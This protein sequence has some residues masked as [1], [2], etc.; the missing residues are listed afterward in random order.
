MTN[1]E[2]QQE[3]TRLLA[4][5]AKRTVFDRQVA[6][7]RRVIGHG[8]NAKFVLAD[9]WSASDAD[10]IAA[11]PD[12]AAHIRRLQA[13]LDDRQA[14]IDEWL[15]KTKWMEKSKNIPRKYL[16]MHKADVLKNMLDDAQRDN[17]QRKQAYT[18][19]ENI[20]LEARSK[21]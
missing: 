17:D 20:L 15:D 10:F 4:L 8:P 16:G 2:L 18:N 19:I 6:D 5:D 12:M 13:A 21:T 14:V 7:A 3:T 11:A 9:C 1:E